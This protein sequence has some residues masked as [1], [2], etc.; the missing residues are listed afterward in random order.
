MSQHDLIRDSQRSRALIGGAGR[1]TAR[2]LVKLQNR[3][4]RRRS[5]SGLGGKLPVREGDN[6][7]RG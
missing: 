3:C 1:E 5:E 4:R 2:P 7:D 6:P